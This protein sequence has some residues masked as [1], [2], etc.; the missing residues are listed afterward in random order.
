M[1]RDVEPV[2]FLQKDVLA[3][4]EHKAI[5]RP[6]PPPQPPPPVSGGSLSSRPWSSQQPRSALGDRSNDDTQ[7]RPST[8]G[9][10]SPRRVAGYSFPPGS[11]PRPE[12]L[13]ANR[14]AGR[15][16]SISAL[17]AARRHRLGT[18]EADEP[19]VEDLLPPLSGLP[20]QLPSKVANW[21]QPQQADTLHGNAS[22][23]GGEDGLPPPQRPP[24]AT[25]SITECG[26]GG[27]APATAPAPP[28]TSR[29]ARP[30]GGEDGGD[31]VQAG[32]GD[33]GGGGAASS[34]HQQPPSSGLADV[35]GAR[36]AKHPARHPAV[37]KLLED[38]VGER[39]GFVTKLFQ[40][41]LAKQL[42]TLQ[43]LRDSEAR[44]HSKEVSTLKAAFEERLTEAVEKVRQVHATN[45]D[46][47]SI[48]ANNKKLRQETA[49]LKHGAPPPMT[50]PPPPRLFARVCVARCA[51]SHRRR[52]ALPHLAPPCPTSLAFPV[53]V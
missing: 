24:S 30:G 1:P 22:A 45:R 29:S 31:G 35:E 46:A 41:R 42:A 26:G 9:G 47:V 28:F 19:D 48:L 11:S 16:H 32:G 39:T 50:D 4:M 5:S 10:A 2:P 49:K 34:A 8:S 37:R 23:C 20:F 51:E 3:L 27:G 36:V 15:S 13:V 38:A 44:L 17:E 52:P 25:P 21:L 40:E 6:Q 12:V 53:V 7:Q 43:G 33:T 18:I 14:M